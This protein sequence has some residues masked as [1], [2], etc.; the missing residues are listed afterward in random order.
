M[1]KGV[2][3]LFKPAYDLKTGELV[4]Y[5]PPEYQKTDRTFAL[6][7]I[8]KNGNTKKFTDSDTGGASITIA[9]LG[10]FA[11]YAF[12]LIYTDKKIYY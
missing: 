6:L 11:G 8:D 9:D 3:Q 7:G 1:L 5:I 12:S 2:D 10:E 4:L